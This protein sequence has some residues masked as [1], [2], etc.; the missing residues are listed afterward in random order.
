M[1]EALKAQ[2][3]TVVLVTHAMDEAETL[4]NRLVI[5][6]RRSGPSS[7]DV[8]LARLP[9][10]GVRRG[11]GYLHRRVQPMI[12]WRVK[13]QGAPDEVRGEHRSLE[14]AYLALTTPDVR[15]GRLT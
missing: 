13:A 6:D 5:I 12:R 1:V 15:K 3:V 2:G 9:R 11:G 10:R 8:S 7:P 4:C 14:S